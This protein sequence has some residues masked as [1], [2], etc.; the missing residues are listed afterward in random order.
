MAASK[1]LSF[2]LPFLFP[3]LSHPSPWQLLLFP[4][5]A[6]PPVLM[7]L[8]AQLLIPLRI[9]CPRLW[10]LCSRPPLL[11]WPSPPS[12]LTPTA[13]RIPLALDHDISASY[14]P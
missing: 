5:D 10:S 8:S 2:F 1:L 13:L 3:P 9:V 12:N 6:D 4:A 7:H 11:W 14:L